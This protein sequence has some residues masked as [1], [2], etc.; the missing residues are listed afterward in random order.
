MIHAHGEGNA[1]F[2]DLI[3]TRCIHALNYHTVI[4]TIV[5]NHL[6][7][8]KTSAAEIWTREKR[9][10]KWKKYILN[11]LFFMF[12]VDIHHIKAFF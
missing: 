2:S 10:L 11:G 4:S 6:F 5:M 9:L 7:K 3:I 1:N 8:R 12:S